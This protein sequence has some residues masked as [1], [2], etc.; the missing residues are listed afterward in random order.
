MTCE[1]S[2]MLITGASVMEN[3]SFELTD[4]IGLVRE[5][6]VACLAERS[7]RITMTKLI[8]PSG[9]ILGDEQTLQECGLQ[10]G[11]VLTVCSKEFS[12][13]ETHY[14]A[15]NLMKAAASN[16]VEE[17]RRVL[18]AGCDISVDQLCGKKPLHVCVENESLGVAKLLLENRASVNR[19]NQRGQTPLALAEVYSQHGGLEP[20]IL[21][22]RLAMVRLLKDYG[23]CTTVKTM[24]KC[25]GCDALLSSTRDFERHCKEVVHDDSFA[26]DCEE[27]DV[28][29]STDSP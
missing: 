6:V 8:S 3:E 23:G 19:M 5:K 28:D 17:A 16:D 4:K 27:V 20:S 7:Q 25:A 13:S 29:A 2:A 10:D 12:M 11:D 15:L 21:E 1:V 24:L 14:S 18:L 22:A 9:E 26:Y